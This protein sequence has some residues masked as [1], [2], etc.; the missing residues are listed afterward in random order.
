MHVHLVQFQVIGRQ[1][2]T[3]NYLTDWIA[4]QY[5][6]CP[7]ELE[8]CGTLDPNNPNDLNMMG[9]RGPPWPINYSPLDLEVSPY[10]FGP[11][12]QPD[13]NEQG[14]KDTIRSN[15]G[16]VTFI[17]IRYAKQDGTG[18]APFF[19]SFNPTFG[20]GYVWHCHIIDHE[21]NEMMRP[22][23]LVINAPPGPTKVIPPV[24]GPTK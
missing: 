1:S 3:F 24:P 9:E 5:N 15:P 13:A 8:P 6:D 23:K 20:P 18:H 11:L 2:F 22:Y 16:E 7:A 17:R 4:K 12:Q 14:W 10:L 21:D 19:Y